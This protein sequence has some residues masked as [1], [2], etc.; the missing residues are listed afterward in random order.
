LLC[1]FIS[2]TKSIKQHL[3]NAFI[4]ESFLMKDRNNLPTKKSC[5]SGFGATNAT[6]GLI[7]YSSFLFNW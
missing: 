3:D 1:D 2:L 5:L 6:F 4:A 7:S